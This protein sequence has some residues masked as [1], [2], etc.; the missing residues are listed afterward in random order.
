[1]L[2]PPSHRRTPRLRRLQR[3]AC[4]LVVWCCAALAVAACASAGPRGE[5]ERSQAQ[6]IQGALPSIVLVVNTLP[7]GKVRFGAGFFD[8]SGRVLTAQ[9]VVAQRTRL[10]VLPY[11]PGRAS[12]SPMDGGLRRYLFENTPELVSATVVRED[13]VSDIALLEVATEVELGARPPLP[14]SKDEVHPGD[15]V[16]AL[17][18]PQ[19]TPWSFS[20]GVVGALQ[21]GLIQHDATVGPGSSGG[22]LLNERGEVVGVNVS[23]V[24]SLPVGLSFARPAHVVGSAVGESTRAATIDFSSPTSAALSCW[25][26]QELALS[27]VAECFDWDTE[28][29]QYGAL[30][31]EAAGLVS[32][33]SLRDRILE[34]G[35]DALDKERWIARRRHHVTRALDP[36]YEKNTARS[37]DP[38]PKDPELPPVVA[39]LVAE[40]LAEWK[41]SDPG[42]TSFA[43]D[44]R[45]PKRLR[46]RLRLG[47][48]VEESRRVSPDEEWVLLGSPNPDGS[49]AHFSELYVRVQGRWLQRGMPSPEDV[50]RLP[51]GWP[52]PLESFALQRKFSLASIIKRATA[53][54]P[55]VS[56]P[57]DAT[58]PNARLPV[59]GA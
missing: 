16:F 4:A 12:Y 54:R 8:A 35:P 41:V 6:V 39:E 21:Y 29:A 24:V 44:F 10:Q 50:A 49:V 18:H 19:E 28:W 46:A 57:K 36:A 5:V 14:W 15:R 26:A 53:G 17:G 22:P 40:G 56:D 45:D 7:D 1:M 23:H 31:R 38:D 25:R 37:L 30:V 32:D 9:H 55:C 11:R 51:R 27:E 48:R 58:T 13:L 47:L 59:G 20:A 42:D 3:S 2:H 43:A 34:C 33:P 52:P